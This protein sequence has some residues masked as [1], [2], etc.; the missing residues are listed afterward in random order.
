M[1]SLPYFYY[2]IPGSDSHFFRGLT[3]YFVSTG[4]LNPT[5]AGTYHGYY[6]WPLFF[7]LNKVAS[8]MGL[9]LH[10][11]E[12]L[13]YGTIGFL[14]ATSLFLYTSRARANG[15]VAVVALFVIITYFFNY[16]WAPFSLAASLLLL[17]FV[18]D[19]YAFRRR[20]YTL[21][22]LVIFLSITLTHAFIPVFFVIYSFVMYIISK[23]RKYLKLFF[24]TL[25]IYLAVSIYY[26]VTFFTDL[27]KQ[28]TGVYTLEY[29]GLVEAVLASS[30]APRPYIDIIAQLFS[31]MTVIATAIVM[32]LGFIIF[33]VKKKL[34]QNDYGIL[35]TGALYAAIGFLLLILGSRAIFL[36]AIPVSLGAAYLAESKFKRYFRPLF[37][38]LIILFTFVLIHGTFYD[39]HIQFQ[40]KEAYTTAN[41]M[42]ERYNWTH[43][44]TILSHSEVRSYILAK[45]EKNAILETDVSPGFREMNVKTYDCIVYSVGLEKSLLGYNFSIEEISRKIEN[46]FNV[47]YN[48]GLSYIASRAK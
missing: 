20:E 9:D 30:M 29:A 43:T 45:V 11:F 10:C 41:F 21:A 1:F 27:V 44:S 42:I 17:L 19:R 34:R 35:L 12:F 8:V 22:T 37:L 18:L 24:L 7:V 40:T 46:E 32:G 14:L 23:N 38:I 13:L 6:Q 39:R 48:S 36:A 3:E 28:L 15:Y 25:T 47:I 26:E 16:Q 2:R 5:R 31:R 4:D 33:A